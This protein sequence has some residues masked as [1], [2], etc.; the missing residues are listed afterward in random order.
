MFFCRTS[1]L[2]HGA[3]CDERIVGRYAR[4]VC[5]C[6][7]YRH[8]DQGQHPLGRSDRDDNLHSRL[9]NAV[10]SRRVRV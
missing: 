10:D 7:I 5:R 2:G 4:D 9:L 8:A 1:F 3:V 6:G